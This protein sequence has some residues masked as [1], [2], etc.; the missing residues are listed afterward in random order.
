M[1]KQT[2]KQKPKL[3]VFVNCH[4]LTELL[5]ISRYELGECATVYNFGSILTAFST[6]L[7]F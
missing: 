5:Y 7:W 2:S 3:V 4:L 1:E 6:K